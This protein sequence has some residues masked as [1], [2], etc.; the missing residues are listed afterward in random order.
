MDDDALVPEGYGRDPPAASA[1]V[2]RPSPLSVRKDTYDH[3]FYWARSDE[4]KHVMTDSPRARSE[5]RPYWR[6][7]FEHIPTVQVRKKDAVPAQELGQLQPFI[8]VF[9]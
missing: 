1:V 7:F 9:S 6:N 8:A 2:K 5:L 4:Y 3:S